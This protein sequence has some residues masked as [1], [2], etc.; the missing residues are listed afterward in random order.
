MR[1]G[2]DDGGDGGDGGEVD[3]GEAERERHRMR[4]F[5]CK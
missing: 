3:G 2:D 4:S 5:C 1:G